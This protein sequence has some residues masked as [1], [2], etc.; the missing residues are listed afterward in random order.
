MSNDIKNKNDSW[1]GWFLWWKVDNAELEKQVQEYKKLSIFKSK[2]GIAFLLE[3]FGVATYLVLF[4]LT[5]TS[6][7]LL[8]AILN[9]VLAIFILKGFRWAMLVMMA[10]STYSTFSNIW[11]SFYNDT[12]SKG[13]MPW[14]LL[15]WSISMHI[16]Y[17][18]L[19]VENLIQKN[20]SNQST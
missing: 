14:A 5:G 3:F 15:F 7:I 12:S 2:R 10:W 9:I 6:Y 20:K 17:Y 13:S 18:A 1:Y 19:R 4:I 11:L 16:L 8:L